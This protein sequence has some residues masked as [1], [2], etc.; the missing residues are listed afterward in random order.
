VETCSFFMNTVPHCIQG[1]SRLY[2]SSRKKV[3]AVGTGTGTTGIF[4]LIIFNTGSVVTF[5]LPLT[6]GDTESSCGRF[7]TGNS[8][9]PGKIVYTR[10]KYKSN[11]LIDWTNDNTSINAKKKWAGVGPKS[12]SN[13]RFLGT[14]LVSR[15]R[16]TCI[17]S[18][19]IPRKVDK[20]PV[21]KMQLKAS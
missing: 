19:N 5:F 4:H 17:F 18:N 11:C 16:I 6:D 8:W 15:L 9:I 21:N 12:R 3:N 13:V 14:C 7:P 2:E 10:L 20:V 1:K